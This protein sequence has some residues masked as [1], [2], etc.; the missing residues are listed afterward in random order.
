MTTWSRAE[1]RRHGPVFWCPICATVTRW[2][3]SDSGDVATCKRCRQQ[4]DANTLTQ[5]A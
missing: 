4:W 3:M 1:V 2:T 5:G